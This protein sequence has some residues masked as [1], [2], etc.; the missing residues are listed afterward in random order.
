MQCK[1]VAQNYG[2]LSYPTKHT[3]LTT[4][5]SCAHAEHTVL[6]T[7]HSCA[8]AEHTVL[9][10]EHSCAHVEQTKICIAV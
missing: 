7:K 2:I 10:T 5:H 9:T 8:H 6:T 3:V 4:E 1:E